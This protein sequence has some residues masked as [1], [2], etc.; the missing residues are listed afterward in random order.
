MLQVESWS[1][2]SLRS[3]ISCA[4][5]DSSHDGGTCQV[6]YLERHLGAQGLGATWIVIERD[7]RDRYFIDEYTAYYALCQAP[8]PAVCTRL[9]FF[10]GEGSLEDFDGLLEDA[11]RDRSFQKLEGELDERYLGFVVVRPIPSVPI[12]RTVLRTLRNTPAVTRCFPG[13]RDYTVHLAGLRFTVRGVAFQQQ[14]QA[15]GACATTAMWSALQVALPRDGMRPP[16]PAA[17]TVAANRHLL[18]G[19]R[20]FPAALGLNTEQMCE[21]LRT[22]GA[23]PVVFTRGADTDPE[24]LEQLILISLKSGLPVILAIQ[25]G[26]AGH[27]VTA[28]GYRAAG[29]AHLNLQGRR[30]TFRHG[31]IERLY[32]QDD[33]LG[34]YARA[35]TPKV[36]GEL[37][38][39]IPFRYQGGMVN[40]ETSVIRHVIVPQYPKLRATARDLIRASSALYPLFEEQARNQGQ[41]LEVDARFARSGEILQELRSCTVRP[42]RFAHFLSEVRLSRYV[43][44]LKLYLGGRDCLTVLLDATD[45]FRKGPLGQQ[46]LGFVATD[47]TLHAL[48]D[49]LGKAAHRPV[50]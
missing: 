44:V 34:P 17:L 23:D 13:L 27:A 6:E 2:K 3:I 49:G 15:V 36:Q 33:R 4:A 21:A 11:L 1:A 8:Y 48:A 22:S 9:H 46:V 18:T 31:Q 39:E 50:G 37:G 42:D 32:I 40:P 20:P 25:N 47:P 24:V 35:T 16:T 7:Y 26:L 41:D 5:G 45:M 12:G 29:P 10:A 30:Q 38:L 28:V 14:D 43:G 19:G